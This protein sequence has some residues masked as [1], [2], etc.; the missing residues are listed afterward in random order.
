MGCIMSSSLFKPPDMR[1]LRRKYDKVHPLYEQ[2]VEEVKY[3]LSKGVKDKKINVSDLNGRVKSFESFYDK[4]IRK[5]ITNDPFES[6][7]DIAGVRIICLYRS[8]LERI[9]ELIKDKFNVIKSDVLR[10][11]EEMPF[12]YM[13][14]HHVVTLPKHFRGERYDAIRSLKCEIQVRTVSMHAWA[15]VSHHLEYKQE[16]DIPSDLKNDFRALSGVFY[17]AD[18]LFQKFREAREMSLKTL[19]DSVE[20]DQ[21]NL[22][23]ELN[24]DTLRAYLY[25]KFPDRAK[26]G[27]ID[28]SDLLSELLKANIN[29]IWKLDEMLTNTRDLFMKYERENPPSMKFSKKDGKLEIRP[30]KKGEKKEYSDVGVVRVCLRKLK[31]RKKKVKRRYC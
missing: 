26:S 16:V 7:E 12:G 30:F 15:T 25:W 21:F 28:Y 6:I 14:D 11:L 4:T 13:S 5:E 2:L 24:F 8:D 23:Q 18:T 1:K 27:D 17:I 3:V 20:M 9:E 22:D 19:V 29:N 10:K 31:K